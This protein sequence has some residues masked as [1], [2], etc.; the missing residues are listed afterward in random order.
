MLFNVPIQ[1]ILIKNVM[2]FQGHGCL[3]LELLNVYHSTYTLVMCVSCIYDAPKELLPRKCP[4]N[5]NINT[6]ALFLVMGVR[7]QQCGNAY[8]MFGEKLSKPRGV[9][10][11]VR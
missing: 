8:Q 3:L 9:D 7:R 11:G 4:W 1:Y 6:L 10:D 2:T 5:N